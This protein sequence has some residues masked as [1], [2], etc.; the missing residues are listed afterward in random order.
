MTATGSNGEIRKKLMMESDGVTLTTLGKRE[1]TAV[2]EWVQ[3]GIL[4]LE[5]SENVATCSRH[6]NVARRT[7]R[8][9]DDG[10]VH[11]ERNGLAVRN[12]DNS[13]ASL[14]EKGTEFVKNLDK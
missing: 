10:R 12:S 13:T 14:T 5:R 1:D 2:R 6:R 8:I 9:T 3:Q 7:Y 4:V 11:L